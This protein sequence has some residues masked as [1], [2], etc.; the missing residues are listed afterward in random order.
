MVRL[1]MR[2]LSR[3]FASALALR[4]PG[5][6]MWLGHLFWHGGRQYALWSLKISSRFVRRRR[7]TSSVWV[8]TFIS[9]SHVR[10]HEIGGCS[11]PSTSTTH[12]R[13]APKPGQLGLVAQGRDLDPVVAA[14]LEDGL[15]LE[16]LDDAAV[17]L[18]ADAR[19][20]LRALR[21]LRLE[22]ALGERI[23]VVGGVAGRGGRR[24]GSGVS[25]IGR[26]RSRPARAGGRGRIGA[27]VSHPAGQRQRR[28]GARRV[29]QRGSYR[30]SRQSASGRVARRSWS[31][32]PSRDVGDRSV[33]RSRS[34]AR[35]AVVTRSPISARRRADAARDGL[36]AGLARSRSGSARRP[37]RRGGPVVD[38]D[39]GARAEVGAGGAQRLEVYGVSSASGGQQAAGRAADE[40][41]P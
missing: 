7:R 2:V 21:R 11:S 32:R 41:R 9:G 26:P 13:Q 17:D 31:H 29:A 24:G 33:S 4:K 5:M 40:R 23:G 39:D 15:A 20:R 14:D 22:Q 34:S 8:W 16:A 12:I 35:T 10:E 1:K 30:M 25:V 38:G 37:A 18:D 6:S 3:Q 28:A 19:R 36:A 27:E